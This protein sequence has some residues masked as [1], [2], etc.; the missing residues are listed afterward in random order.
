MNDVGGKVTH[1]GWGHSAKRN[2][3]HG[4][5]EPIITESRTHEGSLP[6]LSLVALS[7]HWCIHQSQVH[8]QCR[9]NRNF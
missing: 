6:V 2:T 4:Y 7:F 1:L 9:W 8:L 5:E 3:S